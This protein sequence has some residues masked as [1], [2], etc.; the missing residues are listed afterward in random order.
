MHCLQRPLT[1]EEVQENKMRSLQ[2]QKDADFELTKE[3]LGGMDTHTQCMS[4]LCSCH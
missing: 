1:A 4:V 3:L 2:L